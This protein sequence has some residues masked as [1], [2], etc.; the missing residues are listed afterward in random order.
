MRYPAGAKIGHFFLGR[1]Y[2]AWPTSKRESR[3]ERKARLKRTAL[4]IPQDYTRKAVQDKKRR[5]DAL[6]EAK[7]WYFKG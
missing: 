3:V 7:G 4:S 2:C 5:C 6:V 1:W